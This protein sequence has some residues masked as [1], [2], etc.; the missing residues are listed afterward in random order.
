MRSLLQKY[1]L[2]A[3]FAKSNL[4]FVN[5]QNLNNK[6]RKKHRNDIHHNRICKIDVFGSFD[7]DSETK[8]I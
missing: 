7:L 1:F 2:E 4:F 6:Y 5:D 3:A 8:Q